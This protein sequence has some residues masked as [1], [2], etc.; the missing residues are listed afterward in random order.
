[1]R[2]RSICG[3]GDGRCSD[4]E[5]SQRPLEMPRVQDEQPVKTCGSDG[6]NEPFRDAIGLRHLD[7]RPND[8]GPLRLEDRIEALREGNVL[9]IRW[10]LRLHS[11][12]RKSGGNGESPHWTIPQLAHPRGGVTSR[13]SLL[14]IALER[15][16]FMCPK[17]QVTSH[18]KRIA[19]IGHVM[20]RTDRERSENQ[21]F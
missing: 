13:K 8:S 11:S 12:R 16:L 5:H 9:L 10:L 20:S 21:T 2:R 17:F 14:H 18:R 7:G 19:Q 6:S 1:M 4:D 3:V 15:P